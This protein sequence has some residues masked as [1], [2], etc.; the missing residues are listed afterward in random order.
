MVEYWGRSESIAEMNLFE[1]LSS[2]ANLDKNALMDLRS[3]IEN[4]GKVDVEKIRSMYM[5]LRSDKQQV[6]ETKTLVMEYLVRL[7]EGLNMKDLYASIALGLDRIVQLIDGASYRLYMYVANGYRL[8][9][10]LY[11]D[12]KNFIETLIK[13]YSAFHQGLDKL[14]VEP[15]MTIKEMEQV[16]KLEEDLDRLYRSYELKMFK[17]LA[18]NVPALMLLKDAIDFIESIA[19]VVKE[20]A[21]TLR[22][23]ALHR[24]MLA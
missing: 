11:N 15:K 12:L 6:E 1:S 10:D 23:L 2:L 18:D 21:E 17:K 19:D 9:D 13:E 24:V 20:S 14:R 16:I 8:D 5:R 4:I 22:Y 7:G 3:F